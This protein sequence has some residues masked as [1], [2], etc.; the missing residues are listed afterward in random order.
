MY[1]TLQ[2]A[3]RLFP[4]SMCVFAGQGGFRVLQRL[5]VFSSRRMRNFSPSPS[6]PSSSY[7][8]KVPSPII[9]TRRGLTLCVV[10]VIGYR[11]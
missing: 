11:S 7:Y 5:C 1:I 4:R 6:S 2:R 10:A 9:G 3:C 8:R